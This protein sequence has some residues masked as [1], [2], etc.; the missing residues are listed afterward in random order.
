MLDVSREERRRALARKEALRLRVGIATFAV[1]V[2]LGGV[3]L[4]TIFVVPA[5]QGP[6]SGVRLARMGRAALL[7]VPACLLYA[8]VPKLVDRFDPEPWT[9][10]LATYVWG[11]FAACGISAA[12][13]SAVSLAAGRLGGPVAADFFGSVVCAPAIEELTKGAAVFGVFFFVK[14]EFDGIV[15]GI[16]Y[17]TFVGLGFATLEN[18]VYYARAIGSGDAALAGTFVLR[19][20]L[21]PWGHPFYTAMIGIGFGF[22]REDHTMSRRKWAPVVGYA[23]A[24]L[25]HAGWNATAFVSTITGA[26][27]AVLSLPVWFVFVFAFAAMVLVLVARKG[28]ILREFLEDEVAL[29]HMSPAEVDHV[30]DAGVRIR[31]HFAVHPSADLAFVAV[32][33]RLA[34]SKWHSVR[35]MR[36]GVPTVSAEFILPLRKRLGELRRERGPIPAK[37]GP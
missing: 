7:A 18:V 8:T 2:A 20:V 5:L 37:N 12:V 11:A 35:A 16:I 22:A 29:G 9:T 23:L 6:D 36:L 32:A 26:P 21:A 34:L 17:G 30:C 31:S 4:A 10:L 14:R 24:V 25:L 1:G 28:R 27:I 13:T 33:S 19:G 3:L 15:D